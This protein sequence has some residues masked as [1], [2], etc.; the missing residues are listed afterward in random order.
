MCLLLN[1]INRVQ[2]TDWLIRNFKYV[3]Y[4]VM[5]VLCSSTALM[6]DDFGENRRNK[7]Y[8]IYSRDYHLPW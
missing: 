6:F 4:H 1:N 7:E 2:C 3:L 5:S 8:C